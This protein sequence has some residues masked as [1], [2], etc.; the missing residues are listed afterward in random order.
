MAFSATNA[1]QHLLDLDSVC[2]FL[3]SAREALVPG[4]RLILDVFNPDPAKLS[5]SSSVRYVHKVLP[6]PEGGEIRVEAASQYHVATQ[7]LHFDLFYLRDGELLRT[8]QVNMRCFFPEELLALCRFNGFEVI[9]RFGSYE[10]DA[11]TDAS[12]KQILLCSPR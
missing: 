12:P 2:A 9:Q 1:M 7:V 11:F 10:E 6:H 8:K 3:A 5:R 4:G